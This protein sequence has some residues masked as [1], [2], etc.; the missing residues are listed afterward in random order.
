MQGMGGRATAALRRN[1]ASG[2]V[3]SLILPA[4]KAT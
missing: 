2:L 3:V 1:A 4:A